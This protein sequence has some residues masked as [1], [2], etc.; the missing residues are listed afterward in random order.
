MTWLTHMCDINHAYVWHD[1]FKRLPWLIHMCDMTH[2]YV[3][4]VSFICVTWLMHMC[5]MTH[6]YV[7]HDAFICVWHDWFICVTWLMH[8][9]A[10][11]LNHTD[12]S[13]ICVIWLIHIY[14]NKILDVEVAGINC[15]CN[16]NHVRLTCLIDMRDMIHSYVWRDP[17]MCVTWR[18]H[19]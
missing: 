4:H 10:T 3:W 19:M 13:F 12:T 1:Q 14:I 7:W 8:M 6:S 11:W 5:D 15:I 2:S 16:T 17:F 18:M 9:C